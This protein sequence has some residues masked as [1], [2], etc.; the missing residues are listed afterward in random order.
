MNNN[1]NINKTIYIIKEV[2]S[3]FHVAESKHNSA[4]GER[5]K[6]CLERAGECGDF[7][8]AL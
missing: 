5:G 8:P 1:N 3:Q 7:R 4:S 2:H 6:I